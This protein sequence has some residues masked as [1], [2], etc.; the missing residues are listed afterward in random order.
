M[1]RRMLNIVY[2]VH[3]GIPGH[4]FFLTGTKFIDCPCA[5]FSIPDNQTTLVLFSYIINI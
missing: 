3:L 1:L 4:H 5:K 2:S